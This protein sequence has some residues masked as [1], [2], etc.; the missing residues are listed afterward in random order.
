MV[1]NTSPPTTI[2]SSVQN[3]ISTGNMVYILCNLGNV[4][5]EMRFVKGRHCFHGGKGTGHILWLTPPSN[6]NEVLRVPW[7]SVNWGKE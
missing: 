5:Q 3:N 1:D 6:M 4:V 2:R 7:S